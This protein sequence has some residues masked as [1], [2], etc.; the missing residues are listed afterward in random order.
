M[1]QRPLGGFRARSVTLNPSGSVCNPWDRY[2]LC[3]CL[4]ASSTLTGWP[5]LAGK[6]C[7][8]QAGAPRSVQGRNTSF[9]ESRYAGILSPVLE[10]TKAQT[11]TRSLK[12]TTLENNCEMPVFKYALAPRFTHGLRLTSWERRLCEPSA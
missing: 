5:P 9:R 6:G 3:M 8:D 1:R 4:Q 7:N 11:G 10:T 2:T 12:W